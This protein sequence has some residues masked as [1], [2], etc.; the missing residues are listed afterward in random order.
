MVEAILH[1]FKIHRKMKFGNS[2]IIVQNMFGKTPETLNAVD[3]IFRSFVDHVFFVLNSVMFTQPL[4]RIVTSEFV[5]EIDRAFPC[6][7]SDDVHEFDGRDS[8]YNSRIYP[9]IAL[10]KAENDAFALRATSALTLA[11][12]A[13]V[14]LVHFNLAGEF[15]SLQLHRMID[16]LT[17]VLVYSGH[18][19][20]V[21]SKIVGKF[22]GRLYLVE[23]L[24][25]RKLS[26]QLFQTLL[27]L[28]LSALHIP[29]MCLTRL[30][31]TAENTLSTLQKVG[32]TTENVLSSL[33]H[34]DILTPHGYDYH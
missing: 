3:V 2:S 6:F 5:R 29:S 7:L 23:A 30:K 11:P 16:R 4:Q 27:S 33:S 34:M 10:Q 1:F 24:Q 8:L 28:A 13:K 21:H 31:R 19:L 20:V 18:R 26:A 32:R 15:S 9:P 12:A 22:V 17:Q 14:G 25:D